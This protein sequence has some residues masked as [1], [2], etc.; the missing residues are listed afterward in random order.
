MDAA[1]SLSR[2]IDGTDARVPASRGVRRLWLCGAGMI[3]ILASLALRYP[4]RGNDKELQDIGQMAAYGVP[5]LVWYVLGMGAL[6]ALYLLA[7]RES[8]RLRTWEA[9]PPVFGC[10]GA[11]AAVM[12]WMHPVNATDNFIYFVSARLLTVY[13]ANPMTTYPQGFAETDPLIRFAGS[14]QDDLSPYGPLWNLIAVP[15]SLLAGDRPGVAVFGFK[16]LSALCLLAGGWIIARVLQVARPADAATGPLLYLWN[17]LVLWEGVG[18][19]HNDTVLMV[20]VLLALF[21]WVKRRD[22]LV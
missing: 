22:A 7:L 14:W 2:T 16:V 13:R 17:P 10:G 19:G 6:F 21:A 4:L 1:A 12:T 3:A 11:L 9:L 5:E 15:I 8:R 18:N 20:P